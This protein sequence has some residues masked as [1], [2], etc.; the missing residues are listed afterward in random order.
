MERVSRVNQN[1]IEVDE[2]A[3]GRLMQK[4]VTKEGINLK[5]REKSDSDM[6]NWIRKQIEEEV[7][8]YSKR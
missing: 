1:G 2:D 8:C 3:I 6:V 4:I 7:A 5:T